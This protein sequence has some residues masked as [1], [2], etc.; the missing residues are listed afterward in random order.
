[1]PTTHGL[2]SSCCT[3]RQGLA[4]SGRTGRAMV[5]VLA[6]VC[7]VLMATPAAE[8]Q[9]GEWRAYG[10]DTASTKYSP[11][12]QITRD[13]VDDLRIVW[14][15]STIPDEVRQGNT[16]RAPVAS[17][18]APLMVGGRLYVST[19]LGA[20]AAL[21][22]TTGAVD[23]VDQ[24]PREEP[25]RRRGGAT[26][27]LGYWN[28]PDGD[29]ERIIALI[30]ASLVAL[31]AQTG[32]RYPD[33]GEAGE[34]DLR[35]GFD[36][37][38][39]EGFRWQ[40]A[41]LV[42]NDVIIVGSFVAGDYT[43]ASMPATKA[44]VPGDVR[45]FDVRTGEQLWIFHTVPQNEEP[46]T[47]TWLTPV[48]E[49]RPSWEYTGA[50]NM[51]STPSADEELGYVYLPLTSATNDYYGGHRPGG[52]LFAETLVCLDTKTGELVWH[53]QA[54]HHGLWD[55]DF[56][57]APNLVDITVDGRPIKAV[58][59]V[60]KQAFTYV[61]DRATGEPV[62]PIEERP[63][64]SGD[65]PGEWYAPTQP[66]P[67]RPEPFDTQGV[68]VDDLIDFTPELRQEALEILSNYVYGPIFTPPTLID[69]R[70]GG[71]K[72]TLQMPGT[73][74]GANWSGAAMDPET[75]ILYITSH[76]S[77]VFVGL[78]E[79]DHPRSDVTLA[80]KEYKFAQGPQGLPLFKP[81]YGRIVAIDL[82]TGETLWTAA[83]GDGPR[84]HPAI[85]H[86]NLPPLGQG[87]KA[88]PLLTK[89]LLFV[90]E[91]ARAGAVAPP[92]LWGGIGGKMFRAYD[93]ATGE[94]VGELELP[95]G[96]TAAP[97]TYTVD[98][99]QYIVVTVGWED[100]PSEYVALALP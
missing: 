19:G 66:F 26:R 18:N 38:P 67:T 25:S 50:A 62:W 9:D 3:D 93:K 8:A 41:P 97:I 100:M 71:K 24:P 7:V 35:Q 72:G 83:N 92:L 16:M 6:T 81:P 59:I 36:R 87:Y 46:G 69:D 94:V 76:H 98:G 4:G 30:G 40:S 11:L 13:N 5:V 75:G 31:N 70:P 32:E 64:P 42:A 56:P 34:V 39:V 85:R 54:V 99:K 68:S 91:G 44:G 49:D 53:F 17:Q 51:W 14:R 55:Y 84:D 22:A 15:Q 47:E 65:V 82:N 80:R 52:N 21:D 89:S 20:V 86:L 12:D 74:G 63:V 73:S 29:D 43:N 27:G 95:G 10:A 37:G 2:D 1:M 78:V 33:F 28:D 90:G 48:N 96:T 60:S 23:W 79:P 45:G 61:F 57:A 88:S 77:Q 58:A